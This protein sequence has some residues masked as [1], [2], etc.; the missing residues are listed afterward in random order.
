M[1]LVT[2]GVSPLFVS[3]H[4][5]RKFRVAL[6]YIIPYPMG[7]FKSSSI[8]NHEK[9]V[10]IVLMDTQSWKLFAEFVVYEDGVLIIVGFFF[11]QFVEIAGVVVLASLVCPV[12][13]IQFDRTNM[14]L[15]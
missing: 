5:V 9:I 11:P 1:I 8:H 12:H 14:G 10:M 2:T 4:G 7:F 6:Y 13:V 3:T 15:G